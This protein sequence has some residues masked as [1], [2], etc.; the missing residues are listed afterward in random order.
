MYKVHEDWLKAFVLNK[1]DFLKKLMSVS[2]HAV[3]TKL[4]KKVKYNKFILKF[5]N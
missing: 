3:L 4:Y 5:T 1:I 2:I